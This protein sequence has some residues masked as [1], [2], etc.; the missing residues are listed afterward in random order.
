MRLKTILG[1]GVA[2]AVFVGA[3]ALVY[4]WRSEIAPIATPAPAGFDPKLV[5]EGKELALIGDCRTCHTAPAGRVFAGG[6]A[7]PT[8]FGTIYSTNITP[9]RETGIGAWSEAAFARAMREG[10]DRE[11]RHL[12]P[13]FPYDHF[14]LTSSQDIRALYAYFM[15]REPV[16][17]KAPANELAFPVNI[18]LVL[19]GWKLLFF[20]QKQQQPDPTRD[21]QWN[22]GRYLVVGLG[23]CGACHTPR[24]PLG[25]E[26]KSHAFEGGEVEGWRAYALGKASEASIPWTADALESYLAEGFHPDHGVA[27]GPMAAVTENLSQVSRQELAAMAVYLASLEPVASSPS[28]PATVASPPPPQSTGFQ[29]ATPPAPSD[30]G[31]RLYANACAS[32]HDSGRTLPLGAVP[33]RLSTAVSGEGPENLMTLILNGIPAASNGTAP[34]MPAFGDAMTDEQI[35]SL[36]RYLRRDIAARSDW[37]SLE[38]SLRQARAARTVS[39]AR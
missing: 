22:R 6:L 18:R 9:D 27:R 2:L 28:K 17:A 33:L 34:V 25:A 10:V 19:A 13:A 38:A 29:T 23:H 26:D 14:K 24:N 1:I 16:S 36:A 7:M 35:I 37:P 39:R 3:A 8:P 12:Y 5:A 15:T 21:E 32:C 30:P 4:A 11:G 31:A 20:N